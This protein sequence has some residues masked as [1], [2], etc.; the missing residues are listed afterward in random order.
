MV[1]AT[2]RILWAGLKAFYSQEETGNGG[3]SGSRRKL[4]RRRP[5]WPG[6]PVRRDTWII[7]EVLWNTGSPAFAG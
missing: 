5:A 3:H 7:H 1:S 6:D 4:R 2:D